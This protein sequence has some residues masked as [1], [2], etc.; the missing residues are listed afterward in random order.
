MDYGLEQKKINDLSEISLTKFI[1]KFYYVYKDISFYYKRVNSS[2]NLLVTFH[3][4]LYQTNINGI[5]QY[6]NLPVFRGNKWKYNI[7][8]FSDKLLEDYQKDNLKIGW[9]LSTEHN[10]YHNIYLQIIKYFQNN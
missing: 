9:F 7:I 4:R 3:G 8:C 2:K 5:T 1:D 10:D 6:V